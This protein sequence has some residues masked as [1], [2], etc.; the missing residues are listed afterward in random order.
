MA[1]LRADI[2]GVGRRDLLNL[3]NLTGLLLGVFA[4]AA[5]WHYANKLFGMVRQ[6]AVAP[7]L[8]LVRP[9]ERDPVQPQKRSL[10]G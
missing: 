9:Q 1:K 3:G 8:G 7:A 5:A 10:F 6:R 4:I 2:P